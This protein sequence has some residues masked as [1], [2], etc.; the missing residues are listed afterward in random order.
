MREGAWVWDGVS[1]HDN[2]GIVVASKWR[3]HV[4]PSK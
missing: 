4:P 2:G 1:I 3:I